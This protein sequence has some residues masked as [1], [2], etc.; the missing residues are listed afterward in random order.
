MDW[1]MTGSTGQKQHL[2]KQIQI[3][4]QQRCHHEGLISFEKLF[5]VLGDGTSI[6]AFLATSIYKPNNGHLE[7]VPQPEVSEIY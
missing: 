2:T 3:L 1:F 6:E 7:V 4:S 5:P